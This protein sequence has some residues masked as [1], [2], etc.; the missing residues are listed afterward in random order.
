MNFYLCHGP[1]DMRKGIVSLSELVGRKM[2]ASPANGDVFIFLGKDRRNL[3]ILR[4][5]S[6]G[7]VLYWKKLDR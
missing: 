5:E 4:H 6:N 1:V 3:K 7:Y 2:N